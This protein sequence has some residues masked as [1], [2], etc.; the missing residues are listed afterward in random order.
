[1]VTKRALGWLALP[2]LLVVSGAMTGAVFADGMVRWVYALGAVVVT[3]CG[4]AAERWLS[5]TQ[6]A[7]RLRDGRR[8]APVFYNVTMTDLGVHQSQLA[9]A[10]GEVYVD[11]DIDG[12]VRA[13]VSTGRGLVLVHGPALAGV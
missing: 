8:G 4:V 2:V 5:T 11:R 1:M 12:D 3:G 13:A 9:R 10:A 7:L 6:L